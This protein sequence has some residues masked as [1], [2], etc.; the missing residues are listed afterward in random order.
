MTQSTENIVL[1]TRHYHWLVEPV[2]YFHH[3][4]FDLP[5]TFLS[6]R[7][8]PGNKV[9]EAFPYDMAI[10]KRAGEKEVGRLLKDAIRQVNKPLLAI[11]LTDM[12]PIHPVDMEAFHVLESYMLGHPDVAR[13]NLFSGNAE[14]TPNRGDVARLTRDLGRVLQ[15]D[16]RL[17][18]LTIPANTVSVIS[19]LCCTTLVPAIW[20]KEFL[21]DFI[22]D[23]W[24]FDSIELPG[25]Y[26]YKKQDRW[27]SILTLPALLDVAHLCYTGAPTMVKLSEI[28]DDEDREYV[29][30]FVPDRF[31]VT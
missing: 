22:E 8:I 12:L 14:I 24:G 30:Q 4:Y 18:I 3:K 31:E 29:A 13:G 26:K 16:P 19:N 25:K 11:T 7:P 20:S 28:V 2:I 27:H 9:I 5:I 10:Y 23:D 17:S 15:D 6:D 1:V 21:L